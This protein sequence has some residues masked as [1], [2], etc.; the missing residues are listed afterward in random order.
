[1]EVEARARLNTPALSDGLST[2][3]C[4]DE[5]PL[6]SLDVCVDVW[7]ESVCALGSWHLGLG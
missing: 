2:V 5:A 1:M 3:A 4:P 7:R 6:T